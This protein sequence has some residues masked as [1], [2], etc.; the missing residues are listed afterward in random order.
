MTCIIPHSY[1]IGTTTG[2][3]PPQKG[4]LEKEKKS[5]HLLTDIHLKK[6]G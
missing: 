5:H 4:G 1:G 6:P 2:L 3:A